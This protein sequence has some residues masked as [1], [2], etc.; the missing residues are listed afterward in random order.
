MHRKAITATL[1]VLVAATSSWAD[2]EMVF[3][4]KTTTQWI[5]ALS[6]DSLEVRISAA[7]S[8]GEIGEHAVRAIPALLGAINDQ[9]AAVR[10]NSVEALGKIGPGAASAVPTLI[11]LLTSPDAGLRW[12]AASALGGIGPTAAAASIS[13]LTTAMSDPD[14]DVRLWSATSLGKMGSLAAGSVTSLVASLNDVDPGIRYASAQS[15]G[16]IAS[17]TPEVL[18]ALQAALNDPVQMVRTGATDALTRLG[19]Q[20]AAPAA[21]PTQPNPVTPAT[22]TTPTPRVTP[23]VPSAPATPPSPTSF[24][25]YP[26]GGSVVQI[27]QAGVWYPEA[28]KQ[29]NREQYARPKAE[30][31]EFIR[32]IEEKLTAL[33]RQLP[34]G[35]VSLR[36]VLAANDY[37]M[38]N[39]IGTDAPVD[40]VAAMLLDAYAGQVGAQATVRGGIVGLPGGHV[41]Q[42]MPISYTWVI[43]GDNTGDFSQ[44]L[45]SDA[46]AILKAAPSTETASDLWNATYNGHMLRATR[47]IVGITPVIIETTREDN[48]APRRANLNLMAH[49]A[50]RGY[51]HSE[52]VTAEMLGMSDTDLNAKVSNLERTLEAVTM[53]IGANIGTAQ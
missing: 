26:D 15:L 27:S 13:N 5:E 42:N 30:M 46:N 34:A 28:D 41:V 50:L 43:F 8:L 1:I 44:P 39:M 9:N 20:P 36:S 23:T 53:A 47:P 10:G 19:Q 52:N 12:R 49:M 40:G 38:T 17:A 21:P 2:T 4:G 33:G 48:V 32:L 37:L 45:Y 18:A 7:W 24:Y 16:L 51:L 25:T 29:R 35:L 6:S 3:N 22:P 14:R 11:G 31:L